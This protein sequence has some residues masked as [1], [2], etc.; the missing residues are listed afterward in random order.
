MFLEELLKKELQG[1]FVK[2][3]L[4]GE[5]VLVRTQN[6]LYALYI[7]NDSNAEIMGDG[8]YFNEPTFVFIS[9]ST[10]GG[11]AIKVGFIG[12]GMHLEVWHGGKRITTSEIQK[13]QIIEKTWKELAVGLA[14]C[15]G[16]YNVAATV[17]SV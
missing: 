16:G 3:L 7:L 2:D 4:A 8:N 9:G 14:K 12:I 17:P 11:S 6:S 15:Y 5:K 13:I 1:V 10:F